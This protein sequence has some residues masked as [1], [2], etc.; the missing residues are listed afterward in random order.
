MELRMNHVMVI[1][2]QL[3][4]VD[5]YALTWKEGNSMSGMVLS[6][7]LLSVIILCSGEELFVY[8]EYMKD[9]KTPSVDH[10]EELTINEALSNVTSNS[11]LQLAE[12][13]HRVSEFLLL[14]NVVNVSFIGEGEVIV[15]CEN[16]LGLA[17][18]DVKDLKLENILLSKCGFMGDDYLKEIVRDL[19]S[20][21]F[22][23]Y[24]LYHNV[25]VGFIFGNI[26]NLN[27]KNL[28]VIGSNIAAVA[29]NILGNS[30]FD[31]LNIESNQPPRCYVTRDEL[32]LKDIYGG[33]LL[34]LYADN[35]NKTSSF[36]PAVNLEISR[37]NFFNN[38]DCSGFPGIPIVYS[39]SRTAQNL[40]Y[41]LSGGGGLSIL[42]TQL[43]FSVNIKVIE[44]TFKKNQ[45]LY[46]GGVYIQHFQGSSGSTVL[47]ERCNFTEN[48]FVVPQNSSTNVLGIGG[49]GMIFL[50]SPLPN[51]LDSS[52]HDRNID[53]FQPNLIKFLECIFQNNT[54]ASAAGLDF[55]S[56]YSGLTTRENENRAS[57]INCSFIGNNATSSTAVIAAAEEK[58]SG[59]QPGLQLLLDSIYVVNNN[60]APSQQNTLTGLYDSLITLVSINLTLSGTSVFERN[61]GSSILVVT[62]L[63]NING[64]VTFKGNSA[65]AGG[66]LQILTNSHIIL[67]NNAHL[68]FEGNSATVSGGAIYVALTGTTF[69]TSNTEDCFLW[70]ESVD[71]ICDFDI[72]PNPAEI[73]FN[74][75]FI[76]NDAPLGSTVYGSVLLSCPWRR[77]G[78]ETNISGF[79]FLHNLTNGKV[80]FDPPLDD[81]SQRVLNTL[82]TKLDIANHSSAEEP[83]ETFPGTRIEIQVLALDQLNQSVPLAITSAARGSSLFEY[84]EG[85]YS[86]LGLSG[87]WFLPGNKT[88]EKVQLSLYGKAR[89]TSRQVSLYSIISVASGDVF[90][91]LQECEYGFFLENYDDLLTAACRCEVQTNEFRCD[92]TTG[93]LTI[94][95]NYWV[96]YTAAG[97]YTVTECI[98]DYCGNGERTFNSTDPNSQCAPFR[99]GI[100][101]G[102][103]SEETSVVFGSNDCVRCGHEEWLI[104]I[105][106]F[107]GVLMIAVIGFLDFTVA[108]GYVNGVI[109]FANVV[110]FLIPIYSLYL[111]RDNAIFLFISLINF[112]PG[113]PTCIYPGMDALGRTGL[114][115]LFPFY[116]FTL[117]LVLIYIARHSPRL[118]RSGFSGPKLFATLLLLCYSN[119]FKIC[120]EI[121]G[122]VEV[123]GTDGKY[124]GWRVDPNV[125]YGNGIHGFLLAIAILLLL[126][127]ILPFSI[128]LFCPPY[129]L[130]KTKCGEKYRLK[131][132]PIFDAFWAPFKSK[133]IFWP[134][135]RCIVRIVPYALSFSESYPDNAFGFAVFATIFLL[136]H[137]YVQPFQRK[138]LNYLETGLL[139]N[140]LLL[141]IGALYYPQKFEES[142]LADAYII[143]LL[144][145]VYAILCAI[146]FL[147]LKEKF[148]SAWE[149]LKVKCAS[150]AGYCYNCC[151]CKCC[152]KKEPDVTTEEKDVVEN[153]TVQFDEFNANESCKSNETEK[154][155]VT[156]TVLREPLLESLSIKQS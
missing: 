146:V 131:F 119:I 155:E 88:F 59:F 84:T 114:S 42:L 24:E 7:L 139:V 98:F 140:F 35:R 61:I 154:A 75:S 37:S 93:L 129:V 27:L 136:L 120:A 51:S 112:D 74:V 1:I 156:F 153:I 15:T 128:L 102:A 141:A 53:N 52:L 58:Y 151:M 101:C 54:A 135:M 113:V 147:H 126:F 8:P 127:Y 71:S 150:C 95:S 31:R 70:F 90:I 11:V 107:M 145:V 125:K 143:I 96:G 20:S 121:I 60:G 124:V 123:S 132:G 22:L 17:F 16:G 100:L 46:G 12:G 62:S 115:L 82:P 19:N 26:I 66:A 73:D 130:N 5:W 116:L 68:T 149:K 105:F 85:V 72:C 43:M 110:G 111:G 80:N 28:Q 36:Q 56:F 133:L 134:G 106:L 10:D 44:T 148:P 122:Y 142:N 83:I 144:L 9:C 97:K 138:L 2:I 38:S 30:S 25:S 94:S 117:M 6:V 104:V 137:V 55:Y 33:G 3:T 40:G 29:I 67:M 65:T 47:F 152:H 23:F 108:K 89:N 92:E 50:D 79:Q 48:G 32:L 86:Q 109:F 4:R 103:C 78:T 81:E 87:Y 34:M 13:C 91:L 39:S 57:L 69:Y 118:S 14:M 18:I 99:Q 45:A 49:S 21:I 41:V 63:I 77:V 76:D 64:D